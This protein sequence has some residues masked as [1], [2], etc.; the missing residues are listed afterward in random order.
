[1]GVSAKEIYSLCSLLTMHE[2]L[3]HLESGSEIGAILFDFKKVF[4]TVPHLPMLSKLENIG[5]DPYIITRIHN[6]LAER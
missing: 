4:D 3:T 6:Y 5:L 1:M 2:W